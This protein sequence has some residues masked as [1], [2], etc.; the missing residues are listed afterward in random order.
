M[1]RIL[2]GREKFNYLDETE[3]ITRTQNG[4]TEAFTPIVNRYRER[5]Y[6]LIYRWVRHHETAEDLCQEVFLKAW[7]ALPRF[8]GGSL[9]YSWLYRIAIN[10]SKDYLRKQKRQ[11]VFACEELPDNADDALQMTQRQPGPDE[12]LEKE[13]LR[14]IIS[15]YVHQLPFHQCHVFYL[16]YR[17]G[18]LIKEI[19]SRLNKSESTIKSHL[20]HARQK[21]QHM[22]R[23]Y[24]RN[25]AS[26]SSREI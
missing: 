8:K 7:Q 4:D 13:E 9:I 26:E 24:L 15:E 1:N 17:D 10:C 18:L 12:I 25:E 11:F 19:A 14:D 5:I 21:L 23:P 20:Y 6:K 16:H 3:L 2:T 22:L